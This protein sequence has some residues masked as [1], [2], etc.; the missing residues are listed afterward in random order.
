[1]AKIDIVYGTV[2]GN[3]EIVAQMVK[4]ALPEHE[5]NVINAKDADAEKA[6]DNDLLIL[7]CP[8][9]GNGILEQ[10]FERYLRKLKAVDLNGHP[11]AVIGLGDIAYNNDYFIESAKIITNLL[12][13]KTA[14]I[15]T[16]PLTVAKAPYGM[17][18]RIESWSQKLASSLGAAKPS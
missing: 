5:V 7:A 11:A 12:E 4:E 1:M 9:Y 15:I 17:K 2:G 6:K 18:S 14:H 8:T 13:E 10:F 3:T 16:R